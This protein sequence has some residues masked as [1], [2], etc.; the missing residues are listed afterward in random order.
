MTN[1]NGHEEADVMYIAFKGK[2]AVPGKN[3]A[4]WKAKTSTEFQN[5]L[6][7]LGDSLVSQL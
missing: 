1:E 4:A 6:Q 5:S 3:G 7:K 2:Q